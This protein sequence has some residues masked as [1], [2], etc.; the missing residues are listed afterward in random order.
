MGHRESNRS[1][2]H[3]PE[4]AMPVVQTMRI[5]ANTVPLACPKAPRVVAC[6]AVHRHLV[7]TPPPC[8]LA[9]GSPRP[10]HRTPSIPKGSFR[11]ISGGPCGATLSPPPGQ[12]ENRV[13][14]VEQ[15]Y[16]CDLARRSCLRKHLGLCRGASRR[17]RFSHSLHQN[18]R[19]TR[20]LRTHLPVWGTGPSRSD[21]WRSARVARRR[22][23]PHS[24]TGR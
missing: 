15:T 12:V 17:S 11:T 8:G 19:K 13:T 14:R 7:G 24:H 18:G 22:W 6:D 23:G 3:E 1:G 10:Q 5:R 20:H 21:R 4:W 9:E 2:S 16:L